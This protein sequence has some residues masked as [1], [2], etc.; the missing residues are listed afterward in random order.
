MATAEITIQQE[1]A[2][3]ST[4]TIQP[5]TVLTPAT[6]SA[7]TAQSV[8]TQTG[9]APTIPTPVATQTGTASALPTPVVRSTGTTPSILAHDIAIQQAIP[10]YSAPS[11]QYPSQPTSQTAALQHTETSQLT[12]IEQPA[13]PSTTALQL[14]VPLQYLAPIDSPDPSRYAD[15]MLSEFEEFLEDDVD[16]D[17]DFL[18]EGDNTEAPFR[19]RG[20]FNITDV[21]DKMEQ[22]LNGEMQ[23]IQQEAPQHID[24]FS[25]YQ[26]YFFD[27]LTLYLR[28]HGLIHVTTAETPPAYRNTREAHRAQLAEEW[29]TILPETPPTPHDSPYAKQRDTLVFS[30]S[31]IK[32]LPRSTL[33]FSDLTSDA[34]NSVQGES[35][36]FDTIQPE[37]SL[38]FGDS[39]LSI[40]SS[41]RGSTLNFPTNDSLSFTS[42]NGSLYFSSSASQKSSSPTSLLTPNRKS[43]RSPFFHASSGKG[44]TMPYQSP[45]A[46]K[47]RQ[48]YSTTPAAQPPTASTPWSEH[49][50]LALTPDSGVIAHYFAERCE[51]STW[52]EKPVDMQLCSERLTD[53]CQK[54]MGLLSD[55]GK[56]Q[57]T[58]AW[59]AMCRFVTEH[60]AE[61]AGTYVED[62]DATPETSA[63]YDTPYKPYAQQ[64]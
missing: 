54:I 18:T 24:P 60:L 4:T 6:Q 32:E 56:T 9:T 5:I 53:A 1:A 16:P 14:Q 35:L 49:S 25:R 21:W 39:S 48:A 22:V 17:A 47:L 23:R 36:H 34:E 44:R 33:C 46:S 3:P 50:S 31:E 8:A 45:G 51:M 19:L 62:E 64:R 30:E 11:E 27:Q 29:G 10:L 43:P 13:L 2:A 28:G 40:D 7:E 41:K 55:A 12:S 58:H 59:E 38:S 26:S 57:F 63:P 61:K 52:I 20:F 15:S 42:N 37:F